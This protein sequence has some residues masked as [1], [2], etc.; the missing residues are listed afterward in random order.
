M[1]KTLSAIAVLGLAL[2][3]GS[4]TSSR[5]EVIINNVFSPFTTIEVVPS[6]RSYGY[7]ASI[8][9]PYHHARC[10]RRW[11]AY[12]GEWRMSCARMYYGRGDYDYRD[13][14]YRGGYYRDGY[15]Y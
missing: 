13:S 5:A 12:Y 2:L 14:Y 6:H 1:I 3:M 10:Y 11:D 15:P 7:R 9:S 8:W 4:S